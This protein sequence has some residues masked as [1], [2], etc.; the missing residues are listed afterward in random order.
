MHILD[1]HGFPWISMDFHRLPWITM[2][3]HG[4][5]QISIDFLMNRKYSWISLIQEICISMENPKYFGYAQEI[6]IIIGFPTRNVKLE[7]LIT[8]HFM[9][10]DST[11]V[12]KVKL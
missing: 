12:K 9:P 1:I 8:V 11:L 7:K 2:D 4:L 10:T 6:Q 3:Y 5:P